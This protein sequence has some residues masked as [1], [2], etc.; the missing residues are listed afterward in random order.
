MRRYTLLP[1]AAVCVFSAGLVAQSP[2]PSTPFR[3]FI[4]LVS[5]DRSGFAYGDGNIW[6]R[7]ISGDGRYVVMHSYSADLA[8]DDYEDNNGWNDV[9]LRDRMT[10]TTTR[11]SRPYDGGSGDGISE[12]GTISTNGRHVAYA[13]GSSNL[14]PGDT[15][16]HWDVFVRDLD[17]QRTVRISIATDGTQG[18]QDSY[19]PS[20]SADGRFVAFVS[21]STTFVP[22]VTSGS[23]NQIYLHD[24]DAD[25]NG[26][27]DE[28]G[29]A[30]TELISVGF[31][32]GIAD[33]SV[34]AP[35]VTSDGRHVLFESDA[36]N[37][38]DVGNPNTMHH[39]YLRDR[40]TAQ[41]T[42]IDRAM[43]GGPATWGVYYGTSDMTDDGRFITFSSASPDIVAFDMN[44]QSQVFRYDT[45]AGPAA[46]E[47]VTRLPDG[48]VGDGSSYASS[49]S[50]DGRYVLFTTAA[51]NLASPPPMGAAGPAMLAV[52]DM[53]DG[54]FRRVDV[55]DS[56][57]A[58]DQA[59]YYF[60]PAV[61]ADG[62]AV[63]LQSRSSSALG[64]VVTNGAP[65]AFVLTSFSAS[66]V[67][68]SYPMSGGSG[69][70]LVDT[71]AVTRWT[72]WS[73]DPWISV[74][75]GFEYG[76]GPRTVEYFVSP[77]DAGIVRTG[78]IR[79]GSKVIAIHQEGD[80][81]TTPP[82]IT[83]LITGTQVNGWYTSNVTVSWSVS[84]PDSEIVSQAP[85]CSTTYQLTTDTYNTPITCEATSHG[86]V[87]SVTVPLRRDTTPPSFVIT[88]PKAAIYPIGATVYPAYYCYDTY[89]GTSNCIPN[90]P[91]PLDT[92][93]RGRH[94]FSLTSTDEAGNTATKNV[95]YLI[96]TDACVD[97]ALAPEHLKHW[98][99]LDGNMRDG[100]TGVEAFPH[101]PGS[102]FPAGVVRQSW[103]KTNQ[104]DFFWGGD[105]AEALAGPGGL[106]VATWVK[107]R[108]GGYFPYQYS[109]LVYNPRQYKIVRW[110]D[111]TLRW[112]F[113][114]SG[115]FSWV[116][117]GVVVPANAWAHVA[118]TYQ[119]GVVR[120]YLNGTLAHSQAL[121]EPL[122][123]GPNAE[124]AGNSLQIGGTAIVTFSGLNGALDDVMIFDA[125]LPASDI[126][127]LAMSGSGGLCGQFPPALSVTAPPPIEF[128]SLRFMVT[129]T[130]TNGFGQPLAYRAVTVTS[131]AAPAYA[132]TA[133]T[134]GTGAIRVYVP[135]S[136][137][138]P[139]GELPVTVTFAGDG[140]FGPVEGQTTITVL[141]TTPQIDWSPGTIGY[142]TPLGVS[143]LNAVA[144]FEG[145]T[146]PGTFVFSPPAGTVLDAGTH[147]LSA[148]F[149]PGDP[150]YSQTTVLRTI[151]VFKAGVS[152]GISNLTR[153]YN[154][155]P[156]TAT[157]AVTGAGGVALTPFT[158]LYNGSTSGPVNAGTYTI[159]VQY[160]GDN[161]YIPASWTGT[162]TIN[163]ATPSVTATGGSFPFDA[164]PHAGSGAA[165]GVLGEALTP[166]TLTYNGSPTVPIN[167]GT[168]TVRASYAGSQNYTAA[169]SADATLTIT[170]VTPTV[171]ISTAPVY[172][173]GQ[174]RTATVIVRGVDNAQLPHILFYDGSSITQPTNAGTY[175]LEVQYFG[176]PN[177]EPVTAT[178]SFVIRK[179]TPVLGPL[180]NLGFTYDG[181][182]HSGHAVQIPAL[183]GGWLTPVLYT[184]NGSPAAPVNAGVYTAVVRYDGSANYET[185]STTYTL[186]ISK[187][188]PNF[189]W[190]PAL[191]DIIYGTALG[192]N[193]LNATSNVPG[194][195]TYTPPAGTVLNAGSHTVAAV[196]TPADAT[197]YESRSLTRTINVSKANASVL[198]SRP[199]NV[200]YGTAL[201][202]TQLNASASVPGTF[203]YTP[204]AGTVLNTGEHVLSVSFTPDDPANY[205]GG[206]IS[207]GFTVTKATPVV[208]W[209]APAD[210][211]Y[212]TA[213]G[214]AQLNA[215]AN[216]P[217]TFTYSPAAGTVLDAGTR[218]LWVT[219]TP[220]DAANF[221]SQNAM[222]T[223]NVVRAQSTV[224]WSNPADIVYGTALGAAQL[225][226]AANVPGYFSYSP[227]AGTVLTA[228]S[229][230]LSVTFTPW[231]SNHDGS[232]ASVTLNVAKAGTTLIWQIVADPTYPAPLG[233][234]QLTAFAVGVDGTLTY[235]PPAGTVLPAGIHT[236]SVTFTPN[237]PANY[238]GASATVLT[239]VSRAAS[240]ISWPNPAAIV[241]GTALGSSQ[242]NAT[243][244]VP[245]TF[246]YSPAIGTVLS[247]GSHTLSVTF[248]PDDAANYNSAS[249]SVPLTVNRA[250]STVTWSNPSTIVYGT[251]LSG[252]QLN[253]TANVPGTFTYSPA[254]GT[255]LNAGT[256][257][258]TVT[259][260]PADSSNYAS[261]SANATVVVARAASV[262][263][264]ANPAGIVYGT[265]LSGT[266]LNAT[267]NV[268]GT[269]AY[270]PAAGVVLGAGTHSLS[271]AFTPTDAANYELSSAAV[272]VAIAPAA[273]T[274]Q[275]V[276]AGKVYG[277][278]L[279]A[280]TASGAGFVNGDSMASLSGTVTF[281]TTATAVSAP[282]SYPVTPSGVSSP[283]YTIAFAAGTLTVSKASTSVALTTTPNP[284]NNN[285]QVQLR[286][287]VSAVAPGAGTATGAVEFRENGTL[288][289]TATLV[290]G[291]ATFNKSFKRGAHPL[292]ATYVGNANFTGS[293]GGVTHQTQ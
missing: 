274:V 150:H 251:A 230:T 8:T 41:T 136:S 172:Y 103:D 49:I 219:F 93:T 37:L 252:S 85:L 174:P 96:G 277:Q 206:T 258:L 186:T 168:Y 76:A 123:S 101:W 155:Q 203:V 188:V 45:V 264:W 30:T 218:P 117:T 23:P 127:S 71:T 205:N 176:S 263:T 223:L 278:A 64:G 146:I 152:M 124:Y 255:V 34:Y 156:Q 247:A 14:V 65:Q 153:V 9:Y 288:L 142:G 134:D 178:G 290:N 202:A 15:N 19:F 40:L 97:T 133:E 283:N 56:G 257:Q 60:R 72:A 100:I 114:Q 44:W 262:V 55:L 249:A 138:A 77:N 245:G 284:S 126:D 104:E 250:P 43:S 232:T 229:H 140:A 35:R 147:T 160:A 3:G 36:A 217:G 69:S 149:T 280:F 22:G 92:W 115:T 28:P 268:P 248:T 242:L 201:G 195:I 222:V 63:V 259:F 193:Q 80:G 270:S 239:Q 66:P 154:G 61:S 256:H 68:A 199:A 183:G 27:F 11:I 21:W 180:S 276:N 238:N 59:D 163:K 165:V 221:N 26:I 128:G 98:W 191:P 107:P 6:Y 281:T 213:L 18:D 194:S 17:Q 261:A 102:T 144:Q 137:S 233:D 175:A 285:Q 164:Q 200:L 224:T 171:E 129:A 132:E 82:V 260:T 225:N 110:S 207:V 87:A 106:T 58:F 215:T 158:V 70:I 227:F 181:Q 39:L 161:N 143:Q 197:N 75:D 31:T 184:Y 187:V 253:A 29:G 135:L 145:V 272:S 208:S 204:A 241:Y 189:T 47:I 7:A 122:G 216:V 173:T 83:P 151:Q 118:V 192:A 157:V 86:G 211:V 271:V 265:A 166:V 89:S 113:N 231:D 286:A 209:N 2:P 94:V 267:A 81:D 167:G 53:L 220:T 236:L 246:S 179:A 269:F 62:T 254:T 244:N 210:I 57:D 235:S 90:M 4:D 125:A 185:V 88:E 1:L 10:G 148:T 240:T 293:S 12:M 182:P 214:A 162:F 13:S 287:V 51:Y 108:N 226:A 291:V 169:Q 111:G 228:G 279:P 99:M 119:G 52:R 109:T 177:Y 78:S 282:G 54:S 16:N 139:V 112:A 212:G 234:A 121:S 32:G 73:P 91:S 5:A 67:S 130:L 141:P 196:F 243:A 25:A 24:R 266:Q 131:A 79:V 46:T 289:G 273:L 105:A 275:T 292:T 120:T 74:V 84:D 190:S 159:Q 33:A 95:E 237:D 116:N 42:L 170:R 50:G 48:T 20:L 38:S 198:W